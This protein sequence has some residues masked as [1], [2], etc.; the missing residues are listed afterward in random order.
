MLIL[1]TAAVGRKVMSI[2]SG[3]AVAVI[4]EFIIDPA[5]LRIE[6]FSVRGPRVKFFSVL[7]TGDI[8]E[9]NRMGVIVNSEDDIIEVG[10]DMPKV[11]SLV[12]DKFNLNNIGARTEAG[13]RLGK[14]KS[15]VFDDLSFGVVKINV[16][17]GGILSIF[18]GML[19]ID[20]ASVVNVTKK[21]IV[22]KDGFEK[23][24]ESSKNKVLGKGVENVEYG[25]SASPVKV[26][27]DE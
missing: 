17:K 12:E 18:G 1:S 10:E 14:V 7:H 15:F 13:K 20:R 26:K 11:K 2:H 27:E 16:E 5:K 9:W 3:V 21:Y 23:I 6:A 25:F 24:V 4:D 8:R 22:V 19:V